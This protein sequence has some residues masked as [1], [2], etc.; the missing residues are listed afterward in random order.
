MKAADPSA[1]HD[2]DPY[3]PP[4][5]QAV[6]STH[7][8][9]LR[10]SEAEDERAYRARHARSVGRWSRYPLAIA[11]VYWAMESLFFYF[12]GDESVMAAGVNF[13]IR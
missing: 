4:D 10:F 7:P 2:N 9:L 6:V 5:G 3:V 12:N 13:G 1:L 8:I 11:C